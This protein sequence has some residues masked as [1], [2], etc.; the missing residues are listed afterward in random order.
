[1]VGAAF[2][3]FDGGLEGGV[4][5]QDD[6]FRFRPLLLD[7]RQQIQSVGI[8]QFDIQ[9]DNIRLRFL[10]GQLEGGAAVGFGDFVTAAQNRGEQFADFRRVIYHQYVALHSFLSRC[11]TQACVKA[12]KIARCSG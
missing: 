8:G 1:M 6:D 10:E 7:L 3:R 11:S 12:Q 2:G 5:G 9:Q 4:A